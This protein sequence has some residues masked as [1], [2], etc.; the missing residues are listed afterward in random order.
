MSY[1][2]H[3]TSGAYMVSAPLSVYGRNNYL[4]C[5]GCTLQDTPQ[6]RYFRSAKSAL[7]HLRKHLAQ[8]DKVSKAI[9]R[10]ESEIQQGLWG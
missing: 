2:S 4:Q 10:L 3:T 7:E 9:R 6:H 1:C 8:G 5:L